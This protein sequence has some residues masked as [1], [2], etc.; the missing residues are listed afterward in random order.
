MEKLKWWEYIA[1]LFLAAVLYGALKFGIQGMHAFY[2]EGFVETITFSL[3]VTIL[4]ISLSV[5]LRLKYGRIVLGYATAILLF[6][7]LVYFGGFNVDSWPMSRPLFV[8]M[9]GNRIDL[10]VRYYNLDN[11]PATSKIVV[12]YYKTLP[13]KI[14][15]ILSVNCGEL[16]RY[17]LTT[18][19]GNFNHGSVYSS[20]L[21]TCYR[22]GNWFKGYETLVT[23]VITVRYLDEKGNTQSVDGDYRAYVYT[24]PS[25]GNDMLIP[26]QD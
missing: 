18:F 9:D 26:A 20:G 16:K 4:V 5:F 2:Q 22:K 21:E 14:L 1:V 24:E 7:L 10:E 19:D 17:N 13:D 8:T 25:W 6:G 15:E 3:I 12:G 23:D 11:N